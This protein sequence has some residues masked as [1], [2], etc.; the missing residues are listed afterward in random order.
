MS[1]LLF[2]RMATRGAVVDAILTKVSSSLSW[3][4]SAVILNVFLPTIL[5]PQVGSH[6]G[7]ATPF[8]SSLLHP[9]AP[10]CG[11][12]CIPKCRPDVITPRLHL[13]FLKKYYE[14]WSYLDLS[15]KLKLYNGSFTTGNSQF[16]VCAN[17]GTRQICPLPCV[18]RNRTRQTFSL[19]CVRPKNTRQMSNT[20]QTLAFAVCCKRKHTAN[21]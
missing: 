15:F 14:L 5:H 20:Q 3:L 6:C 19:P 16:A 10:S 1:P 9:W 7:Q 17:S 11:H 4:P 13:F 8:V 2:A 21:I 12:G 18:S